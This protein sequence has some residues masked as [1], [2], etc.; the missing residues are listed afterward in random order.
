MN[1]HVNA[2]ILR[3]LQVQLR[4][5]LRKSLTGLNAETTRSD[6]VVLTFTKTP[7]DLGGQRILTTREKMKTGHPLFPIV[8]GRTAPSL[9]EFMSCRQSQGHGPPSSPKSSR[10][11]GFRLC[12]PYVF[13]LRP[14]VS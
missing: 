13:N 10:P 11:P 1:V 7:S 6:R 5:C 9:A 3:V 12:P 4:C 8:S 14:E 2:H